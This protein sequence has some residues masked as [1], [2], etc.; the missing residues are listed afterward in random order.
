VTLTID[1]TPEEEAR[2]LAAARQAGTDV[3]ECAR[4]LLVERL[5]PIPLGQATR[6]LLRAWREEDA[7]ED[8]EQIRRAEEELAE[9]KQALNETRAAAGARLLFP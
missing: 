5:P 7:T 9:F 6:D 2:L 1:L 4:Q 8:P 3:V